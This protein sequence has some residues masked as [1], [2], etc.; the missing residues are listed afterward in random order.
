MKTN[1]SIYQDDLNPLI[2][3]SE[4]MHNDSLKT[5]KLSTC[6]YGGSFRESGISETSTIIIIIKRAR[7]IRMMSH[8]LLTVSRNQ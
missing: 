2:K 5:K 6:L 1:L 3:L 4:Q 7:T 8:N